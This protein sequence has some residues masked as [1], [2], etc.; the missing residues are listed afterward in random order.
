MMMT[1]MDGIGGTTTVPELT[2]RAESKTLNQEDFLKLL[3]AQISTQDPLNPTSETDFTAQLAQ[4]S[5]LEQTKAMQGDIAALRAQDQFLQA[6]NLLGRTVAL[7]AGD[8]TLFSGVVTGLQVVA[9]K[10]QIVVNGEA[11]AL[12]DVLS[13]SLPSQAIP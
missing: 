1:S 8:G 12:S 6:N 9:G 4:F 3:V 10:P 2:A 5:T 13:V 11:H 7:Q